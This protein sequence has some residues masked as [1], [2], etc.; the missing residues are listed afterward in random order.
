MAQEIE[1]KLAFPRSAHASI[2]RHPLIAQ[3]QKLG[4]TQTLVNTYFDTPDLI[5]NK[6]RVAVRTRKAGRTWLQTVKCAADSVGGLSSRP[7]WEQDYRGA[8]DFSAVDQPAVRNLLE[9]HAAAIGPLFTTEFKRETRIAEPRPGVRI[10]MMIDTGW[11]EAGE[12][13]APISELELE[14]EHGTPTDLLELAIAL[15]HDL[16]LLPYDPS[17]GRTRLSAF[18]QAGD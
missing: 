13:K 12:R 18:S 1:L 4:N 8:F 3:A 11:I 5:L 16:P 15:A 14:L 2:L 9:L 7:E 6:A 17:Q 10:H